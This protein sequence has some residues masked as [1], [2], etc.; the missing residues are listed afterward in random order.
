[1]GRKAA[2]V[3]GCEIGATRLH[4]RVETSVRVEIVASV[5]C[6]AELRPRCVWHKGES[7]ETVKTE[8]RGKRRPRVLQ[9]KKPKHNGQSL[10]IGCACPLA[11]GAETA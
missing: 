8:A 3:E 2:S 5:A 6:V 11:Y 10:E 4:P 9:P 7:Q 1:M